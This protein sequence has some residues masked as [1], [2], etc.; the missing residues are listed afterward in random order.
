MFGS[1]QHF[2]HADAYTVTLH[3]IMHYLYT[4]V[5]YSKTKFIYIQYTLSVNSTHTCNTKFE[6][7]I[8]NL[9]LNLNLHTYTCIHTVHLTPY[10]YIYINIYI[11]KYIPANNTGLSLGSE[12]CVHFVLRDDVFNSQRKQRC[13]IL[14]YFL[15]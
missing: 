10:K 13:K 6:F 5:R 14:R 1:I 9:N 12:C 7:K 8:F 15:Q 3:M 4:S 2:I 11:Y